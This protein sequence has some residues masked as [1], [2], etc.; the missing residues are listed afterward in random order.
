MEKLQQIQFNS[1]F[2][3]N[4]KRTTILIIV[5]FVLVTFPAHMAFAA[6]TEGC[7]LF[8]VSLDCDLSGWMKLFLGDIAIAASL[9]VFLHFLA[10]RTQ[11]KLE[12]IIET[13]EQMRNRRKDYAV[14]QLKTLFNSVLYTLGSINKHIKHFNTVHRT[15]ENEDKRIWIS[16]ILLS[17]IRAE[18][19]KMGRILLSA[20]NTLI[21]SND[22][23]NPEINQ[24]ISGTITF[25]VEISRNE[26]EDGTLDFPKY[27]ICKNKIKF[28]SE[29]FSS[30]SFDTHSFANKESFSQEIPKNSVPQS[31][32][33]QT[34]L[35]LGE[36]QHD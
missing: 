7:G 6:V 27:D 20:R 35:S 26:Q 21:A 33:P 28:L 16:G 34:E 31:P 4:I 25:L 12:S 30:Y 19:A 32:S 15:Q 5:I 18:E 29:I 17:E 11:S 2:V 36:I 9:A 14:M 3:N 13:Q 23:L 24:Q 8:D 1:I 22:V 10:H